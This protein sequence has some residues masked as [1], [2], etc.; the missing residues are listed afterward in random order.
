MLAAV[1]GPWEKTGQEYWAPVRGLVTMVGSTV[2]RGSYVGWWGIWVEL[3]IG[4]DAACE[5]VAIGDIEGWMGIDGDE[6][7]VG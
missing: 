2:E 6:L 7:K 3:A 4:R 1:D 5:V